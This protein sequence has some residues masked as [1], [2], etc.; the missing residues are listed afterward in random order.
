[1]SRTWGRRNPT[2][3]IAHISQRRRCH[4]P[5]PHPVGTDCAKSESVPRSVP[6]FSSFCKGQPWFWSATVLF[7]GMNNFA[8]LLETIAGNLRCFCEKT[9]ENWR[10]RASLAHLQYL[11]VHPLMLWSSL[12]WEIDPVLIQARVYLCCAVCA[13]TWRTSLVRQS[14]KLE[15]I[16]ENRGKILGWWR[17]C[18]RV[19]VVPSLSL[20]ARKA[21]SS[22]TSSWPTQLAVCPSCP[23]LQQRR[24]FS[25]FP[26]FEQNCP[27]VF[28]VLRQKLQQDILSCT[29]GQELAC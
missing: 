14:K 19:W 23:T 1:M 16:S 9:D 22:E 17:S 13:L 8:L 29:F 26:G 5:H 18:L 3:R 20:V 21:W 24:L 15:C 25:W 10:K 12:W 7:G 28:S 4:D 6:A 27:H 11:F 2:S